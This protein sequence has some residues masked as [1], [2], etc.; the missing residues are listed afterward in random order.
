MSIFSTSCGNEGHG[1]MNSL[2]TDIIL[3]WPSRST[4]TSSYLR[5]FLDSAILLE[6]LF[7]DAASLLSRFT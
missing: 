6:L 7:G 1:I 3:V 2:A 5:S 4:G